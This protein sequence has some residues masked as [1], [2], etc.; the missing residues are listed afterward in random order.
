MSYSDPEQVEISGIKGR[1]KHI[2]T[3]ERK[4]RN[5]HIKSLYKKKS[6]QERRRIDYQRNELSIS[7]ALNNLTMQLNRFPTILELEH[8]CSLSRATIYHH[9]RNIKSKQFDVEFDQKIQKLRRNVIEKLYLIG[10]SESNV[11]ALE[12]FMKFTDIEAPKEKKQFIQIK[13]VYIDQRTIHELPNEKK[14]L[15]E[16]IILESVKLDKTIH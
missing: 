7:C 13:N 16:N 4:E 14:D 6:K 11:R 2:K 1:R 5:E 9:L 15:L 3:S 12:A 10:V 8:E